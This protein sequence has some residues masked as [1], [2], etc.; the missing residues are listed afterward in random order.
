[1]PP[2]NKTR[3][4]VLAREIYKS[5]LKGHYIAQKLGMHKNTF[6]KKMSGLKTSFSLDEAVKLREIL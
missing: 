4:K 1:M 2:F 3:Y 6:Y 5:G